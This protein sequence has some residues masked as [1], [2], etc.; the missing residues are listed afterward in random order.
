MQTMIEADLLQTFVAIA[1]SGSFT[2]AA[3]RVHRTQS[4]VSMQIKRL[5]E[6]LGRPVFARE[7]RSV[8]LTRDGEMLLGHAR[9]ILKAHQEAL[10]AFVQSDLQGTVRLGTVDE[11]AVPFLPAILA[12]FAE[13]H[14]LVHV[15]VVCDTTTNLLGLLAED[16][17]DLALI[18]HGY[19]DDGGIVLLREPV[20]WV[21]LATQCAHRQDPVPLAL[22]HPGCKFRQWAIDA[23][24]KQGRA[25]RLAYTSVSLSGIEAALRAGLAVSALP[26]SNVGVGFRI[27]DS[28][29]GFPALPSYQI[30]LRRS[31]NARSPIHDCLEQHILDNF[32]KGSPLTV[33]A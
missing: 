1:D 21:T 19:G 17:V 30:A 6:L 29:D 33:A 2:D 14:P 9:R 20:V 32:R 26:R 11:Y 23:L 16:A 13:S 18:T 24:A 31:A 8:S 12:R 15:E 27:L 3:R 10:A 25:Y 4:A 28:Q 5:E 22:F 7:G